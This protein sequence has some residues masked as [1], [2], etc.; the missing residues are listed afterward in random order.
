MFALGRRPYAD[1]P[2]LLIYRSDSGDYK[3]TIITP[4]C[5]TPPLYVKYL[6]EHLSQ[7]QMIN[8]RAVYNM[9]DIPMEKETG[10]PTIAGLQSQMAA[11]QSQMAALQSDIVELKK[12]ITSH[13]DG[14]ELIDRHEYPTWSTY[15]EFKRLPSWPAFEAA[16]HYDLYIRPGDQTYIIDYPDMLP[17][18]HII[19]PNHSEYLKR[20]PCLKADHAYYLD[21]M[22]MYVP[23]KPHILF[24]NDIR[25][26]TVGCEVVKPLY[27][28]IRLYILGYILRHMPRVAGH[29]SYLVVRIDQRPTVELYVSKKKYGIQSRLTFPRVKQLIINDVIFEF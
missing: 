8:D 7:I 15:E 16:E 25:C 17:A 22:R 29:K 9:V 19:K 28:Y 20:F 13:T 1:L 27:E 5:F 10:A 21:Y 6:R 12:E 14:F 3:G 11:L 2:D 26:W 4:E 24:A 18:E 23:S